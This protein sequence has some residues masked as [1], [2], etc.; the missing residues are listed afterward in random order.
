MLSFFKMFRRSKK[1]TKSARPRKYSRDLNISA[2]QGYN[3]YDT[4]PGVPR[5]RFGLY[6]HDDGKWRF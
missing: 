3:P 2:E 6:R 1:T 4:L 5:E